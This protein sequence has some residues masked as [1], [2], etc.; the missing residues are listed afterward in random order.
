METRIEEV[1]DRICRFSEFVPEVGPTGFTFN[2]YSLTTRSP[3]SF[4]P[5][6]EPCSRS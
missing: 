6:T 2:Q 5:A 4:T 1:A 3:G